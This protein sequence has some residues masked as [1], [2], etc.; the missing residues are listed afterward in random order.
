MMLKNCIVNELKVVFNCSEDDLWKV[1]KTALVYLGVYA[2]VMF[3]TFAI[4]GA[5]AAFGGAFGF[6]LGGI[7][8]FLLIA[9][10]ALLSTVLG[11]PVFLLTLYYG[12]YFIAKGWSR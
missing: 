3:F 12:A 10:I 2:V 1:A 8:S 5:F 7:F 6:V 11:I 9:E 4:A